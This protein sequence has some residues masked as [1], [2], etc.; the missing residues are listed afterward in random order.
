MSETVE[1]QEIKQKAFSAMSQDGLDKILAGFVL[2]LLPLVLID[3]MLLALLVIMAVLSLILKGVIRK[4][5]LYDRIGYAKFP[6]RSDRREVL[7]TIL[8]ILVFLSLF[9]AVVIR[10]LNTFKPL[11]III[12]PAGAFFTITHFRTKIK[13][14]YVM[15]FVIFLS[16]IIGLLFTIAGYDPNTVSVCQFGAI[17]VVFLIVGVIQLKTFLRRYQKVAKEARDDRNY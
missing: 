9:F 8:Y 13:I 7:F 11:M 14:D 1:I 2:M 17:G 5:L 15:S 3:M 10:Q 12:V 4:K 6:M 16:G